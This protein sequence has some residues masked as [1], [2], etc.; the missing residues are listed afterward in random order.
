MRAESKLRAIKVIHTIVWAV[1]A[2]SIAAIPVV[3][4]AGELRIAWGLIAFVFLEV[5]VL[6]VNRMTC[7]LTD[8]AGR[9]TTERQDNF[10][11]YLPLWLARN[12][13]RIFGTL[14]VAAVVYALWVSVLAA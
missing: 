11:I 4:F 10:D 9:Y 8:V 5:L 6:V 1:F 14:Y 12:N 3:T 7:P 13:K 2:G